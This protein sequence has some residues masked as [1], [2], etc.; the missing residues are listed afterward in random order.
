[1]SNPSG[2]L[3]SPHGAPQGILRDDPGL[4]TTDGR[5]ADLAKSHE[6]TR[7]GWSYRTQCPEIKF[8]RKPSG[9]LAVKAVAAAPP[10]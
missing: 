1:M 9:S 4:L 10:A 2:I 5:A 7:A 8:C 3:A 6:A